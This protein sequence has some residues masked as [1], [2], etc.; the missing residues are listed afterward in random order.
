MNVRFGVGKCRLRRLI[1][2]GQGGL[3]RK[4]IVVKLVVLAVLCCIG[5]GDK[6]PKEKCADLIDV[7]CDRGVECI[8]GA[9][10]MHDECV[11]AVEGIGAGQ[12]WI[13]SRRWIG[14]SPVAMDH[15][16]TM[17]GIRSHLDPSGSL[18]GCNP[19]VWILVMD[20]LGGL[21]R[22]GRDARRAASGERETTG[23][24]GA[25]IIRRC[26]VLGR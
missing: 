10:G 16:G 8:A 14:S 18:S 13:H 9:A 7:V 19:F 21:D 15:P 1:K 11:H 24:R 26:G 4:D 23:K 25:G 6:S 5:C 3:V 20:Q 17:S 22:S 2:D 12:E